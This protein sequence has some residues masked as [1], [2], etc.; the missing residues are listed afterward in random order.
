MCQTF[1]DMDSISLLQVPHAY[2]SILIAHHSP[3]TWKEQKDDIYFFSSGP[4]RTEGQYGSTCTPSVTLLHPISHH[5]GGLCR[6]WPDTRDSGGFYSLLQGSSTS[7]RCRHLF[8]PA[9]PERRD[10][11]PTTA[12]QRYSYFTHTHTHTT[13]FPS[14]SQ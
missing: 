1:N 8:P 7:T 6:W 2:G 12:E 13:A 9:A 5:R 3:F 4:L 14:S 11:T 10:A